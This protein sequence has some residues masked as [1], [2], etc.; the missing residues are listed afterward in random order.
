MCLRAN[1]FV[2][3]AVAGSGF[4]QT[5][6]SL[7][8]FRRG[9]EFLRQR[10]LQSA[11]NEFQQTLHGD[12]TP[13]WTTVWSLIDLGRTFDATGQ[14]DRA[15]REYK[16]ALAT[17]DNTFGALNIANRYIQTVAKI[18]DFIPVVNE[19]DTAVEPVVLTRVEPEYPA[20]ARLAGLEGDIKVAVQL[21]AKGSI[22][23]MRLENSL[24]LGLDE[25]TVAAVRRWTFT[26][27]TLGGT[28]VDGVANVE[29]HFR[30]PKRPQGW[31]ATKVQFT[32]PE[33]A[34]PDQCGELRQDEPGTGGRGC[35]RCRDFT[36]P[37]GD[38]FYGN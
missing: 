20:E 38:P 7:Q 16:S 22:N 11:G 3:L 4:A 1:I 23:G 2:F 37:D 12:R 31:H 30:L 6:S 10:D 35:D 14:R 33:A 15:I 9:E 24:G 21:G 5:S 17:E 8:H 25:S 32:K 27:A 28:P 36:H 34:R 13:S 18:D 29:I 19:R 26:P